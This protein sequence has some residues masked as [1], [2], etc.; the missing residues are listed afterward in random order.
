MPT[1]TAFSLLIDKYSADKDTE[2]AE[3]VQALQHMYHETKTPIYSVLAKHDNAV[4]SYH[5]L[6]QAAMTLQHSRL[7]W[8]VVLLF[9]KCT[10]AKMMAF[11]KSRLEILFDDGKTREW[12][13]T[14][15]R[16]DLERLEVTG[17]LVSCTKLGN[18]KAG[19]RVADILVSL[20]FLSASGNNGHLRDV[21]RLVLAGTV[22]CSLHIRDLAKKS[23]LMYVGSETQEWAPALLGATP[24]DPPG[25]P[26]GT[27][28]GNR[29]GHPRGHPGG[30]P[31]GAPRGHPRGH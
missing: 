7:F 28:R 13:S 23:K 21:M 26:P 17:G 3:W 8:T 5:E 15:A 9:A 27:P 12:L 29:R 18:G 2:K 11:V 6:C 1:T 10:N 30:P 20:D 24:G 16:Q 25:D 31:R 22:E 14:G 19:R 4:K